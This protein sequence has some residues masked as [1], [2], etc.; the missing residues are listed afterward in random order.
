MLVKIAERHFGGVEFAPEMKVL[1][2]GGQ[3]S[4]NV[5]RNAAHPAAGRDT[6]G[7]HSAGRSCKLQRG[8]GVYRVEERQLD[9]DGAGRGRIP[10]ADKTGKI[11]LL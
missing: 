6:A 5:E 8:K 2:L 7:P 3:S 4:A 1:H 10:G 11:R 9:A